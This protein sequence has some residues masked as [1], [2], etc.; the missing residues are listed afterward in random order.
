MKFHKNDEEFLNKKKNDCFLEIKKLDENFGILTGN[1]IKQMYTNLYFEGI[2]NKLN[3]LFLNYQ[4]DIN[5]LLF[6][7]PNAN[8]GKNY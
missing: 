1:F 8:E 4:K 7:L 6:S 3:E 2:M 5:F